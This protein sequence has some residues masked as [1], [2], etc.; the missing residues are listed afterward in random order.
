MSINLIT[1]FKIIPW[2]DVL[3]NAPA[4]VQGAEKLWGT[5]TRK[6]TPPLHASG[7]AEKSGAPPDSLAGMNARVEALE[8]LSAELHKEVQLSTGL[9]KSLAE[10]NAQLV[11][12]VDVLRVRTRLLTA[13]CGV[14]GLVALIFGFTV[15]W[16]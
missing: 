4:I 7:S 2:V 12:A 5:L 3:S 16:R 14:L 8:S 15:L 6:K 10:Q 9:I 11:Q 1:A 13:A